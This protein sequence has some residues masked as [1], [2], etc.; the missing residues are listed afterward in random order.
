MILVAWCLLFSVWVLL[1]AMRRHET[2][3]GVSIGLFIL[4]VIQL[5][6]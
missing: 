1:M 5:W 6:G 2:A 4:S 3:F